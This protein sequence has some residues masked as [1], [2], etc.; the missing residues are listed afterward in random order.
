MT[1]SVTPALV[2]PHGFT[3]RVFLR[4]TLLPELMAR[5]GHVGIFAPPSAIPQFRGELAGDRFSFFPL[6]DRE[7]KLDMAAAFARLFFADWKLTPTREIRE[8]EEWSK[9]RLRRRLWPAHKVVGR[10]AALRR[11]WYEAENRLLP[12]PFHGLA[13]RALNPD[14]VV[15]ATAGVVVSD[16]RLI[17]RARA[18]GVPSVTFTQGWDNLTSKTI[19]GAKPDR[20]IVWNERMREE[21]IELH[22]FTRDQIDV[23]GP[24]HFDP[25]FRRTGWTDRATFLRSLG[26]DPAKRI[27]LY[28]T[29]PQRYFTDS[30][31]ITEL[32]L[33]ANAAGKFGPDVQL[34]IRLHPQVIQGQDADD[35]GA[36]ERFRGR[37]Y[38]DMPRGATGLAADYTPDGIAHIA[39]LLD[40]SA[41]TINVA[42]SIS[43][44][45][46]IFDTPVINLRFDAEP[47]RPYLKSVRRQYDT[48]HYK[49][50]V[51]TG[52]VRLADSP[53]ALVDEVRR[54]L[55]DPSHERTE[56]LGLVRALCYRD[57]GQAGAR[58]A[59]AITGIGASHQLAVKSGE[60]APR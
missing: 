17:R 26:L 11:A 49:Q 50:V 57:D 46:A 35:L 38:L 5:C 4:S 13:F 52:A 30:I 16:I 21:A 59:E 9:N 54:Y 48:D 39:Q 18:A 14:V 22:G 55:S 40:A 34:V 37:V 1:R 44:D 29:S 56:R 28:A 51:E 20:L 12:D 41:V 45:A 23:T 8:Q 15:T 25:Y 47:G 7:R 19:V 33:Q 27:V 43:I 3:A 58:V 2:V 32:L 24:P 42:S 60:T 36:W 10:S 53:E 31:A 6:H